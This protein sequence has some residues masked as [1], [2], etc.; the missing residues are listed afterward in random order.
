L[1]RDEVFPA[2]F[3]ELT[4]EE[5]NFEKFPAL[6]LAYRALEE[7]GTMPA[8]MNAANETAVAA[9]LQGRLKFI[10]IVKVV[11]RTMEIHRTLP[12]DTIEQILESDSWARKTAESLIRKG[13]QH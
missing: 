11:M 10:E 7:G 5:A 6:C 13:I 3:G 1:D 2:T 12:G 8:V 9:F 4:F